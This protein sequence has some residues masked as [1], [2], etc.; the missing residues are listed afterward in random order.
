MKMKKKLKIGRGVK[1]CWN[2]F[3]L[4]N[5]SSSTRLISEMQKRERENQDQVQ[6]KMYQYIKS[7]AV[8]RVQ[9]AP[10]FCQAQIKTFLTCMPATMSIGGHLLRL[11]SFQAQ[12]V[13]LSLIDWLTDSVQWATFGRD[14]RHL[15]PLIHLNQNISKLVLKSSQ[16]YPQGIVSHLFWFTIYEQFV[17]NLSLSQKYVFW[18][19]HNK[20]LPKICHEIGTTIAKLSALMVE[21]KLSFLLVMDG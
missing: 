15:W 20:S 1:L 16:H 5:W 17:A 13:T 10:E 19:S 14:H 18:A 9:K 2:K 7:L 3:K 8:K 6:S 21:H 11:Q 4:L 12:Y